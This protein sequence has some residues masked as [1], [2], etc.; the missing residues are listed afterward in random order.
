MQ[1][2]KPSRAAWCMSSEST[3]RVKV[4][5]LVPC[6]IGGGAERS[7]LNIIGNLNPSRF[8]P[9]LIVYERI[10]DYDVPRGISVFCIGDPG[11]PLLERVSTL[12]RL[13]R[14][15]RMLLREQKPD[16]LV[17]FMPGPNLIALL[18]RLSGWKGGLI[19]SERAAPSV[20]LSSSNVTLRR[21]WLW[22]FVARWLY[23]WADA[24]LVNAQQTADELRRQFGIS[25]R[26][27]QVIP[28]VV[29]LRRIRSLAVAADVA[30]RGSFI[31]AAGR[32]T[33]QKGFSSLL[34][35]FAA[36]A[37]AHRHLRLIIIGK[38]ELSERLH[39]QAVALSIES[40]VEFAGFLENPYAL[41]S[42]ATVFVL[43]SLY[44]GLPNALLEAMACG[45]PV[46]ASDCPG[47][48]RDVVTDGVNGILV[49]P[50]DTIA[51]SRALQRMLCDAALRRRLSRE[52]ARSIVALDIPALLPRYEALIAAV[53]S[54]RDR[55]RA[56]AVSGSLPGM[57][58]ARG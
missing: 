50:A 15:L 55:A 49:P 5:F 52:A 1:V 32:L 3:R 30:V 37:P 36:I 4:A 9:L 12:F 22:R 28:N 57:P 13:V 46:I 44:E 23:P 48:V 26:V 25:R 41:M 11:G 39:A 42:R 2:Y 51:L 43:P 6:L 53:A 47:G 34:D 14:R 38:G 18:T 58:T 19:V 54:R 7:L 17:S 16:V 10:F 27:L 45:A 31:L 29:P 33:A 40:R 35:A 20:N 8:Q 24:V 56:S 21:P